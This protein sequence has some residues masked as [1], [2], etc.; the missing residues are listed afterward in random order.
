MRYY[1]GTTETRS[2]AFLLVP[3]TLSADATSR[4]YIQGPRKNLYDARSQSTVLAVKVNASR[5]FATRGKAKDS[6]WID[7]PRQ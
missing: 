6:A 4:Q 1:L 5:L 2:L 7:F 3:A